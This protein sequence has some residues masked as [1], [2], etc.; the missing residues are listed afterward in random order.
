[1][2]ITNIEKWKALRKSIKKNIGFVPTMGC[3]HKGHESLMQRSVE[4]NDI[5]I[6]SIFVN[7]TQFNDSEDYNN[8]PNTLKAD[9]KMA[10]QC[11]VDFIL[12]PTKEQLYPVGTYTKITSTHPITA[13]L[14]G[15]YRPGHLDGVLTIVMKLLALV[16]PTRAYFGEKDYQQAFLVD[17]L[18]KDYFL[19]VDIIRCPTVREKSGMPCSSRNNRLSTEE[20]CLAERFFKR[21]IKAGSDDIDELKRYANELGMEVEYI[22]SYNSRLFSAIQIG[23]IRI[24]DNKPLGDVHAD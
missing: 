6:L 15:K 2:L 21:F 24:I 22:E 12:L 23:K 1:M 13:R 14:E 10:E 11:G 7:P 3:L 17:Q 4:E 16:K 20:V 18:V 8:Y 9:I 5:T 19:E